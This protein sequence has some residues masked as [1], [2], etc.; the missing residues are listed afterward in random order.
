MFSDNEIKRKKQGKHTI[1]MYNAHIIICII[2]YELL[3]KEQI[4][5]SKQKQFYRNLRS[6]EEQEEQAGL[7]SNRTKHKINAP[8]VRNGKNKDRRR[9]QACN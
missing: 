8:N 6:A 3:Q 7:R 4:L 9:V 5:E 2:S 1:V